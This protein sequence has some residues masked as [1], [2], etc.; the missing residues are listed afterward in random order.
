MRGD[1]WKGRTTELLGHEQVVL[2]I[3]PL[4]LEFLLVQSHFL[5]CFYRLLPA[6]VESTLIK[7]FL[8]A[9]ML[10]EVRKGLLVWCSNK[11]THV[12]MWFYKTH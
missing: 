9:T 10:P 4:S 11:A 6:H 2:Q 5:G 3:A 12:M 8:E 7:V 1:V